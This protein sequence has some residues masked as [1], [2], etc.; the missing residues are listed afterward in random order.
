MSAVPASPSALVSGD[1]GWRGALRIAWSAY[2]PMR[3][4]L[5]GLGIAISVATLD[6][7]PGSVGAWLYRLVLA[8]WERFDVLWYIRIARDGYGI[9]DGRAAFHPLLP[10]LMAGLGR[11]LAGQYVLAGLVINDLACIGLLAVFYRLVAL[12][13]PLDVAQK[14]QHWLLGS[15]IGFVLLLPY[16]ESLT[17]GLM[18]LAFWFARH[19]RWLAAGLSGC[20]ATLAKQPAVV[21]SLVLL[22]EYLYT[23][24]TPIRCWRTMNVLASLSLIPLG[25]IAFSGYRFWLSAPVNP[26]FTSILTGLVVSPQLSQV[27][28]SRFGMPTEWLF[29]VIRF[30]VD[31]Y[32]TRWYWIEVSLLLA[33]L[34]VVGIGLRRSRP[35]VLVYSL[36]QILL[37]I[38]LLIRSGDPLMSVPRRFVLIF[39]I[40]IQLGLWSSQS[41]TRHQWR[42]ISLALQMFLVI[43]FITGKFIP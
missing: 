13:Y 36:L 12:D 35:A 21:L 15:P 37:I 17:L 5:L 3:L 25:Y 43:G 40:P 16:T 2:W 24:H 10:L 39:S 1:G 42:F 8:P 28:G 22:I 7:R 27:W 18:L 14:A 31:P 30:S 38:T 9:A 32:V 6:S 20:L 4:L 23:C 34:F 11:I 33:S 19:N 29:R 26:D 41:P